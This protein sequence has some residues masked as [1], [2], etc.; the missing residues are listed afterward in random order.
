[1]LI[2]N[3]EKCWQG[4][5]KWQDWEQE[6]SELM[7]LEAVRDCKKEIECLPQ[8]NPIEQ[9]A[10][11]A[12]HEFGIES[13]PQKQLGKYRVDFLVDKCVFLREGGY[14]N[15][16]VVVECDGHDWHEKTKEQAKRDKSMD[17]YLQDLEF[18]VYRFTGSEIWQT[19]GQCI[20]KAIMGDY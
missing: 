17:R 16:E 15:V 11:F 1:M 2:H 6:Y 9:I 20:P 5:W 13:I 10:F 18:R 8:M 14:K 4:F 3:S 7:G 12:L 19:N